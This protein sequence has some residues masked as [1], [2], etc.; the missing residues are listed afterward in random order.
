MSVSD[1]SVSV[2]G[3]IQVLSLLVK[4]HVMEHAFDSASGRFWYLDVPHRPGFRRR[5]TSTYLG[6]SL[7]GTVKNRHPRIRVPLERF[8]VRREP[9]K[10]VRNRQKPSNTV[11]RT[12]GGRGGTVKNRQTASVGALA[13]LRGPSIQDPGKGPQE[14]RTN[15]PLTNRGLVS[16]RQQHLQNHSCE[17]V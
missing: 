5:G 9:S 16:S 17:V 6:G 12:L 8:D 11:M 10:A 4:A 7:G 14:H 15:P 2:G 3:E 13:W 1:V